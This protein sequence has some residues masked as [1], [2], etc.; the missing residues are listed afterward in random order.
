MAHGTHPREVIVLERLVQIASEFGAVDAL[1]VG[2]LLDEQVALID[3]GNRD[4][5]TFGHFVLGLVVLA[6]DLVNG[7][8]HRVFSWL[9][10]CG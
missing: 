1:F 4:C 8:R 2:E 10:L 7:D 9:D 6:V 5:G 3:V